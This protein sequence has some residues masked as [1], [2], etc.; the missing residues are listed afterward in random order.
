LWDVAPDGRVLLT[1]DEE[2]GAMVAQPPG[3]SAERDL[4]WLDN[5][6]VANLSADGRWVMFADRAGIYIRGTDGSAPI[7]LGYKGAFGDDLSPDG[8]T[9]LATAESLR[10]LFLVPK[11][12]GDSRPVPSHNI[13]KYRGA[14]LFPDGHRILF[15]GQEAGHGLRSYVQD[16]DGSAPKLLTPEH[17]LAL[18]ISPKGDVAAAIGPDQT[19]SLWPIA[20]GPSR[21]VTGSQPGE[22]PVAWSAD[23]RSL[24]LFRRDEV[25]A[26]V[27]QLDIA[28]GRRQLWKTLIPSD[29]AGVYSIFRF[30]VTPD[31]RAYAYSYMRLLSQLYVVKGLK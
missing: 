15:V 13:I 14:H 16:L 29:S 31:G 4:S 24:W 28:N 18:S 19:I 1:Q 22:R 6:S 8:Q 12:A 17:V 5:S 2:R 3:Q 20:G 10:Q 7:Y 23:G 9:V 30:Q 26:N 27:Y 11:G 25:P 21:R